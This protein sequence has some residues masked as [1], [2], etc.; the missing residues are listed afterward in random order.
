MF[1]SDSAQ[2]WQ[3]EGVKSL[4][5]GLTLGC[6]PSAATK[7]VSCVLRPQRSSTNSKEPFDHNAVEN[8]CMHGTQV[9]DI[10]LKRAHYLRLSF[11]LPPASNPEPV[12]S[13]SMPETS[14]CFKACIGAVVLQPSREHLPAQRTDRVCKVEMPR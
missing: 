11:H 14:S 7:M 6:H 4:H 1:E 13:A 9:P 2:D 12:R 8:T 5:C 10:L 3:H